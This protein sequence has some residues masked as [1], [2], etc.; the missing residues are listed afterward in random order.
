MNDAEDGRDPALG[1]IV[2][3]GI[4]RQKPGEATDKF[5]RGLERAYGADCRVEGLAHRTLVRLP[6]RTLAVYEA[7]WADLLAGDAV[8]GSFKPWQFNEVAWFPFLNLRAGFYGAPPHVRVLLWTLLLAPATLG[9]QVLWLIGTGLARLLRRGEQ[10]SG[11]L[12][13]V[14]GDVLNYVDSAGGAVPPSSALSG[15]A[16]DIHRRFDAALSLAS[17]DGCREVQV[18]AHSLGT[19]V[20]ASRLFAQNGSPGRDIVSR[21]YTI[22][23][24]VRRV[25]FLWPMLFTAAKVAPE[26]AWFNFWDPLDLVSAR[27]RTAEGWPAPKNIAL[28]G[29]AGLARAHVVYEGHPRFVRLFAQGVGAQIPPR[30]PRPLLRLMLFGASLLE[31]AVVISFLVTALAAGGIV[32]LLVAVVESAWTAA[33]GVTAH[34][35]DFTSALRVRFREGLVIWAVGYVLVPLGYGRYRAA[36]SHYRHRYHRE[37]A[38]IKDPGNAE[39]AFGWL[40]HPRRLW[41]RRP[42]SPIGRAVRRTIL[43]CCFYGLGLG[44]GLLVS[45]TPPWSGQDGLGVLLTVVGE[46]LL[47]LLAALFVL[48]LA[49]LASVLIDGAL[50]TLAGYR[51][52]REATTLPPTSGR[53]SPE[54]HPPD[55]AGEDASSTDSTAR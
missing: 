18:V 47:G 2:V 49:L 25:R 29:R 28:A 1:V 42:E 39:P 13:Q 44:I 36:Y 5:V 34:G 31:S 55:W 54:P 32:L 40:F 14:L 30:R 26:I 7:F 48:L 35:D 41:N 15:V 10:F 51:R 27:V 22:G 6:G 19:V 8:A 33:R 52:W 9:V 17:D 37:P 3:H 20:A 4:G 45:I 23:S 12:D 24:P 43:A 21:L 50:E 16:L 46:L 38:V 53:P 11:F